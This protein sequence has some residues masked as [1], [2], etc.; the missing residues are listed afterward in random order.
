MVLLDSYV[1]MK[2]IILI[3]IF[4]FFLISKTSSQN[5]VANGSF[6]DTL[7][8]W[9]LQGIS[10]ILSEAITGNWNNAIFGF[11]DYFHYQLNMIQVSYG[12]VING[13]P[14]NGIPNNMMASNR[15]PRTGN[16]YAG[17]S[18]FIHQIYETPYPDC[19]TGEVIYMFLK[20]PME[21]NKCYKVMFYVG[22]TFKNTSFATNSIS[23]LFN[24]HGNPYWMP[25]TDKET[26]LP[27]C[28]CNYLPDSSRTESYLP[29]LTSP[30]DVFFTD[31]VGWQKIEFEYIADG[32][33][34]FMYIGMLVNPCTDVDIIH[35][36]VQS[37]E[38]GHYPSQYIFYD[39]IS[40]YP[41]DAPEYPARI[42]AS[43]MCVNI[44]DSV[45]LG[46]APREQYLYWWINS[47]GDTISNNSK[48]VVSPSQTET[49]VLVQKDFKF[50]ETRD[51]ITI[52]VEANCTLLN[53]SEF[54]IYPNPNDGNFVIRFADI[55]PENA[56]ITIHNAIGKIIK[57]ELIYGFNNEATIQLNVASG[58]YMV[59]VI[60]P[61]GQ[62]SS[63]R[64]VVI[65]GI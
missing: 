41:C 65:N 25:Y 23:I 40:V 45:V 24:N 39:D 14:N 36:P 11:G 55:I 4:E 32:T 1:I 43:R 20:Y 19:H 22:A 29:Q 26:V 48:I 8:L 58:I 50:D 44:G 62:I 53:E 10:T 17:A 13:I 27:Y 59:T 18:L 63:K 31:T 16:A 12:D 46:E 60:I 52:H 6:E 28:R 34:K 21:A 15:Y 2:K 47:I 38:M 33:E 9:E 51:T 57:K 64:L 37:Y 30:R 35:Y 7:N 54:I 56:T 61:N 42:K 49:Y 3:I 5:L